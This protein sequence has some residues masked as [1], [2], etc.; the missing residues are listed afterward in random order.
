[1]SEDG[2]D[3]FQR[4]IKELRSNEIAVVLA[5]TRKLP[6]NDMTHLRQDLDRF[7][8]EE[9]EGYVRS[10][11][12]RSEDQEAAFQAL[13]KQALEKAHDPFDVFLVAPFYVDLVVR[14]TRAGISL[15]ELPE[16][17]DRW[18]AEVLET[19]LEAIDEGK[20]DFARANTANRGPRA[21]VA[22]EAV[23]GL[24]EKLKIGDADRLSIARTSLDAE[25]L[26]L[27]DAENLNLLWR[28]DETVGFASEDLGAY[29]VARREDPSELLDGIALVAE[30]EY[31]RK[32]RDRYL[33]SA[34]IFWHLRHPEA[35]GATF[36]RF[37]TELETRN[38]TRPSV[39]VTAI[40]IASAC[41]LTAFTERVANAAE[42]CVCSLDTKE[43]REARPWHAHELL[44]LVR[45][46]AAWPCPQAHWLLWK[47]AT[48]Q[49]LEIEWAA[50][51]ALAMSRGDPIP[52]LESEIHQ[53]LVAAEQDPERKINRP[54]DDTGQKIASLAWILPALRTQDSVEPE[55]SRLR[56]ICLAHSMSPL[57]G[58]MA[59]AQGLKLAILN[60]PT[61]PQNV[62]LVRELLERSGGL[63]FWHA[64]LVLVQALLAHAWD[65]PEEAERIRSELDAVIASE[66]HPLVMKGIE[67][68]VDGLLDLE[69]A[70][71]EPP[72][73][74]KYMY[75]W[76][77]ER[78]AVRW[79]DVDV[80]ADVAQLA[81]DAVLLSNMTYQ[82]REHDPERADTT[83]AYTELPTCI[84]KSSRRHRIDRDCDGACRLGLCSVA[85][86][87][88]VLST[89]AQFSAGF[90]RDQ[91]RLVEQ[92]GVPSW[93][94][95]AYRRKQH[96]KRFWEDQADLVQSI[97]PI[98]ELAALAPAERRPT[99]RKRDDP[100]TQRRRKG[101][102]A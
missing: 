12:K 30:S 22:K 50:A 62:D 43:K 57:R 38:W 21:R 31:P 94:R 27:R 97:S 77:H 42:A 56:D 65:H 15:K 88:A 92:N 83:A 33:R 45:A 46:L 20:I 81:A 82:L 7:N 72:M 84:R 93:I 47:L 17:K 61:I 96:L 16:Q 86:E 78:D 90:C 91:A 101:A 87:P 6:L 1:M 37:L 40:R 39:V 54:A 34:L 80:K 76:S 35:R 75:M 18:R 85:A 4:W 70:D 25:D 29:L 68:A 26:A 79:T 60:G 58:E 95:I 28:G 67:L 11:L 19:Y 49:D 14:L 99:A 36:E 100:K 73:P 44:S 13:E 9:A 10:R 59:L 41:R 32:R 89:R 53:V 55:F 5:T 23:E 8:R 2:G 69:R 48:S 66:D 74:S 3:Q 63:R 52:T 51:K 102:V 24:A 64:R 71:G 98:G